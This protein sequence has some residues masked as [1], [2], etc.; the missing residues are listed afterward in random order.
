MGKKYRY[1]KKPAPPPRRF[2]WLWAVMGSALLLIVGGLSILWNPSGSAPAVTPVVQ[3]APRL[4]V[5][6]TEVDEGNIPLNK[7][8]RSSFQ[9]TNIGDQPLQILDEP[10]V[11]LVEGC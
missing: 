2:P 11:E 8:V 1:K 10:V 5:D 9:L 4:A 6:R 7:M 3:G